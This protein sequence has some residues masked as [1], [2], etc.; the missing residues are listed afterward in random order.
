[1]FL[2]DSASCIANI[3]IFAICT[4]FLRAD[5]INVYYANGSGLRVYLYIIMD[6]LGLA[7]FS[8]TP[9][10]NETWWYMSVAI[11]LIFAIPLFVQLYE[12]FGVSLLAICFMISYLGI[13]YTSFTQYL[14]VIFFGIF[15]AKEDIVLKLNQIQN[16]YKKLFLTIGI[17]FIFILLCSVR[18]HFFAPFYFWLDSCIALIFALEIFCLVDLLHCKF[19]LLAFIGKH[20]TNIFLIHTL[21]FK[22]YFTDFVYSF[23]YCL[24]IT[25]ALLILSL[26]FSIFLESIKTLLLRLFRYIKR[27]IPI[28]F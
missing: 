22:Y 25:L 20:S 17:L 24:P 13:S 18:Y 9:T 11:L 26:V 21:L 2:K 15:I 28:L 10:Y 23:K 19:S 27:K 16:I 4:S 12:M 5:G 6:A 1:M 14:T 7:D 3:Y 8:R